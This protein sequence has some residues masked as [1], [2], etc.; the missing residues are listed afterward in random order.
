MEEKKIYS[1]DDVIE[2]ILGGLEKVLQ[3]DSDL[4]KEYGEDLFPNLEFKYLEDSLWEVND[5]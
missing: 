4:I 5:K 1:T 2:Q 3:H